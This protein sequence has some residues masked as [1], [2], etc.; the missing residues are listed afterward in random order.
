MLSF[1]QSPDDSR[2][3]IAK[4]Y[5]VDKV[6]Y[7]DALRIY[8]EADAPKGYI[9]RIA[10]AV[11]QV[12]YGHYPAHFIYLNPPIPNHLIGYLQWNTFSSMT[13]RMPEWT[14][15]SISVSI[16]DTAGHESNTAALPLVLVSEAV[17]SPPP[18]APFDKEAIPRLGYVHINLINPLDR[19]EERGSA[20]RLLSPGR[21]K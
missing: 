9:S 12:G 5:A 15:L 2:P 13:K 7:G 10:V 4:I 14:Q 3:F 6:R 11:D 21:T 18:P 16:F 20:D 17:T 8:F 19:E 1:P